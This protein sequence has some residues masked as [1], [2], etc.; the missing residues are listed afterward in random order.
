MSNF[1][2]IWDEEGS[3]TAQGP[4]GPKGDKGDTGDKGDSI[5]VTL[6]EEEPLN[7][8]IGDFWIQENN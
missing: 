6:S 3:G 8:E 7:P 4:P 2:P 5:Q 1:T